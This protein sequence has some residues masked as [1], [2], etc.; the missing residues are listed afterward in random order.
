M[1]GTLNVLGPI[2]TELFENLVHVIGYVKEVKMRKLYF[3]SVWVVSSSCG[4][5]TL[6]LVVF[7]FCY[8]CVLCHS[9]ML[10]QNHCYMV[11]IKDLRPFLLQCDLRCLTHTCCKRWGIVQ[12]CWLHA[13]VASPTWQCSCIDYSFIRTVLVLLIPHTVSLDSWCERYQWVEQFLCCE[14]VYCKQFGLYGGA[15]HSCNSY[16]RAD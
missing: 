13:W 5:T 4:S 3:Y 10:I 12:L 7:I 6:V 1:I 9:W 2:L 14:W 8:C 16:L 11:S 15:I